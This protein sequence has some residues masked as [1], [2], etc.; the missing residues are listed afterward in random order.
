MEIQKNTVSGVLKIDKNLLESEDNLQKLLDFLLKKDFVKVREI[1][2]N[3]PDPT[4][5][6]GYLYNNIDVFPEDKIPKIIVIIAK[7]NA[8]D[9]QVRD[10]LVNV[11]GCTAEIMGV[12]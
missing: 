7:Y 12:L 2:E 9:A 6:F 8:W 5:L 3:L 10:K 11:V 1:I 4:V